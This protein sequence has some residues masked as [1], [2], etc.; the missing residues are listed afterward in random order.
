MLKHWFP[1]LLASLAPLFAGGCGGGGAIGDVPL[2]EAGGTVTFN[3]APLSGAFVTLVPENGPVAMGRTD[4]A[5]KFTVSTGGQPGA[6][7]G[8]AKVTVTVPS[9]DSGGAAP[10]IPQP[11]T[12]EE[13]RAYMEKM[14]QLQYQQTQGEGAAAAKPQS[15]LP[16]KYS[17]ADTSGLTVTVSNDPAQNQ[18]TLDLK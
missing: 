1:F 7:I 17:K 4:D 18:F 16:E 8:N 10:T 5:G 3:G 12:A 11:K 2:V 6:A 13:G 9:A 14:A 15:L